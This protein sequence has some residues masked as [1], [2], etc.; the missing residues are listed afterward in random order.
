MQIQ[1]EFRFCIPVTSPVWEFRGLLE[2]LELM[3]GWEQPPFLQ[4]ENNLRMI[5]GFRLKFSS[6]RTTSSRSSQLPIPI[7]PDPHQGEPI[8]NLTAMSPARCQQCCGTLR[9]RRYLC[10]ND[11]NRSY[12]GYSNLTQKR[13]SHWLTPQTCGTVE[14][15]QR[16]K[17]PVSLWQRTWWP[18]IDYQPE[19]QKA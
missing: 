14:W 16:R 18:Q 13:P 6:T 15:L 19:G 5:S 12:L 10:S 4:Y 7:L 1:R 9:S 8:F 17:A 3:E 2:L 11:S